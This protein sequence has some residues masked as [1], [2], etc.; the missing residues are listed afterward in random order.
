MAYQ[1]P[2][3]FWLYQSQGQLAFW[4][5][6]GHNRKKHIVSKESDLPLKPATRK[7]LES[8][9]EEELRRIAPDAS[10]ADFERVRKVW[11]GFLNLVNQHK[12]SIEEVLAVG[13]A[14][15]VAL[16]LEDLEEPT[17]EQLRELLKGIRSIPSSLREPLRAYSKRLPR[18][19]GG[20]RK[21]KL[22]TEEE[23][24]VCAQIG[25]LYS[26]GVP[27]RDAFEKVSRQF[28]GKRI[29]PRTIKRTWEKREQINKPASQA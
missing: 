27:L 28:K 12:L 14:A 20:G 5:Q 2:L 10:G 24:Q 22:T 15:G 1:A 19:E 16:S 3:A 21:P 7:Q 18:R 23:R 4:F 29:S 13:V 11:K 8:A 17:P 26:T 9:L 25:S 6:K